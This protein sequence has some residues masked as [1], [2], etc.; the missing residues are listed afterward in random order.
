MN[1]L[2]VVCPPDWFFVQDNEGMSCPEKAVCLAIL[3]DAG[4]KDSRLA[5]VSYAEIGK[6][7]SLSPVRVARIVRGLRDRKILEV[8]GPRTYVFCR[9]TE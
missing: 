7:V 1:R 4:S 9:K 3:R 8:R 2:N 5:E 6:R